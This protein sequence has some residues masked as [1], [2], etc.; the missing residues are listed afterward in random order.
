MK[1]EIVVRSFENAE[2]ISDNRRLRQ[3]FASSWEES[4]EFF[5]AANPYPDPEIT[6]KSLCDGAVVARDANRPKAIV[7]SQALE[8]E[9]WVRRILFELLV[10]VSRCFTDRR[11]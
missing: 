5:M 7:R 8:V 6:F 1:F 4:V 3:R 2:A 9:R 10:G 11:R